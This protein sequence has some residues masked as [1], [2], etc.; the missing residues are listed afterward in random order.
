M[1]KVVDYLE[2]EPVRAYSY[3]VIVAVLGL[4]VGLGVVTASL[5]PLIVTVAAVVLAVGGVEKARAA[6]TPTQNCPGNK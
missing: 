3:S 2:S 1:S 5:V 6:V 4:L